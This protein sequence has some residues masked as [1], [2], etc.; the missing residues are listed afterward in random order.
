M[1]L[2]RRAGGFGPSQDLA[3][4][5]WVRALAR[6]LEFLHFGSEVAAAGR[7]AR[8]GDPRH[9]KAWITTAHV[10]PV[11]DRLGGEAPAWSGQKPGLIT[12]GTAIRADARTL[13][14]PGI[15]PG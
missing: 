5:M 8:V 9:T 14:G 2:Q 10:E 15:G 13:Y 1:N 6:T 3:W 4:I 7:Q 11:A 12:P